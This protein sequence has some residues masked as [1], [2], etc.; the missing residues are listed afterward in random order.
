MS[1]KERSLALRSLVRLLVVLGIAAVGAVVITGPLGRSIE[2]RAYDSAL[3]L[4]P[5]PPA[6]DDIVIIGIDDVAVRRVGSWPWSRDI[7]GRGILAL[8]ALGARHIVLDIEYPDASPVVV[9]SEEFR[10]EVDRLF[11]ELASDVDALG[12]ALA[13]EQIGAG[14][15]A[16][17]LGD[18]A[19]QLVSRRGPRAVLFESLR[20]RDTYLGNAISA[21]SATIVAANWSEQ[22][23]GGG[24]TWPDAAPRLRVDGI[25]LLPRAAEFSGPID[26]VGRGAAGIGFVNIPV[27]T[28]GVTR[29]SDLVVRTDETILPALGLMPLVREGYTELTVGEDEF[30]LSGGGPELRVPRAPDGSILLRWHPGQIQDGFRVVSFERLIERDRLLADL[31]Y[32]LELMDDAGYFSVLPDGATLFTTY[33]RAESILA[34]LVE[35]GDPALL[36]QYSPRI[37]TFL[38]DAARL[39][40]PSS[41]DAVL[42]VLD[43]QPESDARER[44]R[45][46]VEESFELATGLLGDYLDLDR[47]LA[48]LLNDATVF[49]GFTA[50]STTDLGVTP[51]EEAYLNV[52]THATLLRTITS[53]SR[54][55]EL[56]PLV[57]LLVFLV[58]IVALV[59]SVELLPPRVATVIGGGLVLLQV[60]GG[61]ALFR[62]GGLYIPV[63][64]ASIFTF[65]AFAIVTS[66]TYLMS[67]RDKREIRQAFE[68]YLSPTVISVL[69]EAPERLDVGGEQRELTALF[70]DIERFTTVVERLEPTAIVALLGDY[71]AEMTAPILDREGTI[72][73]YEGDAIVSFFGAPLPQADH[74]RR[75]CDAAIAMRRLEPVLNDRLVRAG[76]TPIP[77]RTRIGIH[78]GEM[79]VGNLGTPQRLDYTII[80]P[81]V[82]L[83]S[84]LENVNKQYKTWT[85]VSEETFCAAGGGLLGRRMDR[86]RVLGIDRP[87]RLYELLGYAD[88]STAALREAL[89][90]FEEGLAR[91]E[92]R[93]WEQARALFETVLRIYPTDGPAALFVTRCNAFIDEGVRESW[94]GIISLAEK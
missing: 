88:E 36:D 72:D 57:G 75:A 21:S 52:G 24:F 3:R 11:D 32:Y 43:E 7:V 28:D 39:L 84:R 73:K 47:R 90:L 94:D 68:H 15:A 2:L 48:E 4:I 58:A 9:D 37:E 16:R 1:G 78:S 74:A 46:Q 17:V 79:T 33:R 31:V 67:E 91:F 14:G 8:S 59:L 70:T 42:A 23:R 18:L 12:T 20:D 60:V 40:S 50:T 30:V 77:L 92:A 38:S 25:D 81:E 45:A 41:R 34:D 64:T 61:W 69:L 19:Q 83:A 26:P 6:D 51:F 56:P 87:V 13:E 85:I 62:L 93:E 35:T 10:G 44:I 22:S 53:G 5:R 29:R 27:D 86:V 66:L 49:I 63:A 76:A 71:L 54:L 55:D 82:N 89:G 80:G 65:V